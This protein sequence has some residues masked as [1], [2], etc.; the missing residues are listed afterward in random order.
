MSH[1][2]VTGSQFVTCRKEFRVLWGGS[3][4]LKV[5]FQMIFTFESG[6]KLSCLDLGLVSVQ[7]QTWIHQLLSKVCCDCRVQW[8]VIRP[9]LKGSLTEDLH[10]PL[11]DV[12]AANGE[13]K[14]PFI[15]ELVI[16][17]SLQ[18]QAAHR[19]APDGTFCPKAPNQQQQRH[20]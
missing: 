4:C 6:W 13:F 20:R 15:S 9:E 14:S 7:V 18:C 5:L 3:G 16:H 2:Q 17:Q 10:P 12:D 11:V 19:V 1:G 8:R